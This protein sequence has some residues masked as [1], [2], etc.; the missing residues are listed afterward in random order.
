M[1][2]SNHTTNPA[3]ARLFRRAQA[4]DEE[5]LEELMRQ[6]DGLVHHII[7]RQ[8][9]GSLSYAQVLQEGRIG[10][11][12]AILGFDPERRTAFSTYAGV[13]IARRV[14]GAVKRDRKAQG[15]AKTGRQG[16]GGACERPMV[17]DFDPLAGLVEQEIE[18][19]LHALVA[20]LPVKRRQI[21]RAYYGL[22]GYTPHTLVE[23]GKEW[24]CTKQ[25]VHYHLR[26]ALHR[27]RHPAFSAPLRTLLDL[28]RRQ[29]YLQALR[30]GGR[31]S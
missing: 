28:N 19:A 24:G 11:W 30:P 5:S 29:D 15:R 2:T 1:S 17:V 14:W 16:Q 21:V 7:R 4:G 12:R 20:H 10:L 6:H 13:A 27:L 3:S 25:A 18:G 26:R 22:D 31:G 9:G 8:W 23:L